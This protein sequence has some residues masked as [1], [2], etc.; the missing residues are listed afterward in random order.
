MA[1]IWNKKDLSL[2]KEVFAE[3]A[4]IH[5]TMGE[6]QGISAMEEALKTW[7]TAFPDMRL[8]LLEVFEQGD[9]V[10]VQW[11]ARGIHQGPFM[12]IEATLKPVECGGTSIYQI[13]KGKVVEY[14]AYV[15]LHH[16]MQQIEPRCYDHLPE[17][18][19]V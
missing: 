5:S 2:V 16:V 7:Y 18:A 6:A 11:V 13:V 1:V 3:D 14:W 4:I 15:N 17:L 9:R 19:L 10:A 12:G 8:L